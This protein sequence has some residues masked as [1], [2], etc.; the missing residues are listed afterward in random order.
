MTAKVEEMSLVQ[1]GK[2]LQADRTILNRVIPPVQERPTEDVH[3]PGDEPRLPQPSPGRVKV[4]VFQS[5][6]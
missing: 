1:L 2:Y 5:S 6:I 4:A 3:L